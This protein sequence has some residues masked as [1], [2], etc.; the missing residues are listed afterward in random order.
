MQYGT[1]RRAARNLRRSGLHR[2]SVRAAGATRRDGFCSVYLEMIHGQ[3]PEVAVFLR[4]NTRHFTHSLG[5]R[6]RI[7][8]SVTSLQCQAPVAHLHQDL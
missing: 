7:P 5:G 6:R 4:L 8:S 3:V 1:V 2:A